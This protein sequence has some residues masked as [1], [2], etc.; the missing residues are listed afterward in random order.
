MPNRELK[1]ERY[2]GHTKTCEFCKKTFDASRYDARFCSGVCR[3][4]NA[5]RAKALKGRVDHIKR[6][7]E[8]VAVDYGNKYSEGLKENPNY[9]RVELVKELIAV[10]K[11]LD[12]ILDGIDY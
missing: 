7:I 3:S 6:S 2:Y 1:R 5:N 4:A 11:R 8:S 9:S 10:K 12:Q